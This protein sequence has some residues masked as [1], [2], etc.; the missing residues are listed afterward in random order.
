MLTV[1]RSLLWHTAVPPVSGMKKLRVLIG[2]VLRRA[3]VGTRG[4]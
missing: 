3:R 2:L 1:M 4:R